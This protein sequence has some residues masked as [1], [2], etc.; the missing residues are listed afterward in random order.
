VYAPE[1]K[2]HRK[3]EKEARLKPDLSPKTYRSQ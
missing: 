1:G 2:C 3:I